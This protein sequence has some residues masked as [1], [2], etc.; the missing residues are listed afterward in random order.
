M[1]KLCKLNV[2][3]SNMTY[4]PPVGRIARNVLRSL[5]FWRR[6]APIWR[7]SLSHVRFDTRWHLWITSHAAYIL[8]IFQPIY[9]AKIL[10]GIIR[11]SCKILLWVMSTTS[12][13][14]KIHNILNS[15]LHVVSFCVK[16]DDTLASSDL[17]LYTVMY[18]INTPAHFAPS[19]THHAEHIRFMSHW[20]I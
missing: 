18:M 11:E 19:R 6:G 10:H 4:D 15:Y 16:W 7:T 17:V 8:N 14:I 9:G 20:T 2:E 13:T 1:L 12:S 5:H 3:P